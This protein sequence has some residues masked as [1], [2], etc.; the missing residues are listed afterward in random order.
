MCAS[1]ISEVRLIVLE[2]LFVPTANR[3]LDLEKVRIA[4]DEHGSTGKTSEIWSVPG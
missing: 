3:G 4:Q 1:E 2:V